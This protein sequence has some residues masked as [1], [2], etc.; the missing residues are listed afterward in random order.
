VLQSKAGA[1][2]RMIRVHL[3]PEGRAAT[4]KSFRYELNIEAYRD[5]GV[6]HGAYLLRT[7]LNDPQAAPAGLET[8]SGNAP[9]L[10]SMAA[11]SCRRRISNS[12]PSDCC[13]SWA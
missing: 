13:I 9:Q 3:P 2:A 7:N 8:I 6:R 10:W 5:A 4:R 12:D 1:V 11:C